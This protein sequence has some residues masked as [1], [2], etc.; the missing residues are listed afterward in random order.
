MSHVTLFITFTLC[1]QSPT[2]QP[3]LYVSGGERLAEDS[4]QVDRRGGRDEKS[5]YQWSFSDGAASATCSGP[6][7]LFTLMQT[8][9]F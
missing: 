3:G 4:L 2:E 7:L 6:Q 8:Q 5:C 9:I 1:R